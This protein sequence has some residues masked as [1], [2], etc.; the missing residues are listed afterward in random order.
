MSRFFWDQLNVIIGYFAIAV[1]VAL[2][3]LSAH[4]EIKDLDLWLHVRTG[5][6]ITQ[7]LSVPSHDIYSCTIAGKAW[8]NH[9]WLFQVIAAKI[10]A[11]GGFDALIMMQVVV[12]TLTL[13]IL[14]LSFYRRDRQGLIVF[15]L[16]LVMLIY[17]NRLTIR[18]DIYS[19]LFVTIFLSILTRF[20]NQR[21][22]LIV[23]AAIQLCWVNMHGFFFMG[24]LLVW[25]TLLGVWLNSLFKREQPVVGWLLTAAWLIPLVSVIN[26]LGIKGAL[27]PVMIMTHL[28][29]DAGVFFQHI[30]ELARPITMANIWTEEN[31]Y[32]KLMI[33]LTT[34]AMI[35]NRRHLDARVVLIWL[36]YL[37]FSLAAVRNLIFFGV[38]GYWVLV[39]NTKHFTL[40]DFS[41][42]RFVDS[43]FKLITAIVIKIILIGW[44][45]NQAA[46]IVKNGY[47]DFDTLN[48]KSELEGVSKR[49]FPY[50]AVD[51]I[52]ANKIKGNFFNDFNSGAYLIGRASPNV[53]VFIDGRTEQYGSKFFEEYQKV[54]RK[55]NRQVFDG[56]VQRFNI[57]GAFLNSANQ[58][59]P[60]KCARLIYRSKGW[61][62]VYFDADALILLK[63]TPANAPIIK[64]YAIDLEHWT[65][66]SLDLQQLGAKRIA[67]FPFLN[68]ATTLFSL[69]YHPQAIRELKA[70]IAI[71]PDYAAAYHL[72]GKIYL[73]DKEYR[74]AFTYLRIATM[75][76]PSDIRARL[77]LA[78]SYEGIKDFKG[79]ISQ[80]ARLLEDGQNDA[81][82]LLGLARAH[83]S[84]GNIKQVM[85]LF[86]DARVRKDTLSVDMIR[87]GDV[88]F[89]K[90]QFKQAQEIYLEALKKEKH[91]DALNYRIGL[92]YLRTGDTIAARKYFQA[93]LLL[94]PK[95]K[96]IKKTLSE[97]K[98][99]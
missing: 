96:G 24:P 30:V 56:F 80:Y 33:I 32:Y 75:M 35:L 72:L 8:V 99:K 95:H 88:L 37:L 73:A 79:A 48:R 92:T 62:V 94:N 66:K 85:M 90:K 13:L 44:M 18:P 63:D 82:V 68:R 70:A 54:W 91:L 98:Q 57:T 7:E 21:W 77:L 49:N 87:L 89:T 43:R 41:P 67:P 51:F 29:H 97:M 50:K 5:Q 26:P 86:N 93:G 64:K 69:G 52:V 39:E 38:V 78:Q 60:A 76:Y 58:D 71:A 36:F 46:D 17:Q 81:Q 23:L 25:L 59:I 19:V 15:G 40:E 16:L 61:H 34:Y 14:L 27:Y 6:V 10:H 84:L 28:N 42:I 65:T 31:A 20:F 45:I 22:G 83:A 47:F 11:V 74:Q 3:I 9:E 2:A 4:L 1:I 55:G 12:V 53:K